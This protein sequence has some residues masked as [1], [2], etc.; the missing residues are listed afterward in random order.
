[1]TTVPEYSTDGREL[2]DDEVDEI[3]EENPGEGGNEE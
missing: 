2:T 3:G 1:M